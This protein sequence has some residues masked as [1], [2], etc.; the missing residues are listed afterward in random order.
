MSLFAAYL[1][2]PPVT[3][4]FFN[5][6]PTALRAALFPTVAVVP[7]PK[8]PRAESMAISPMKFS[9]SKSW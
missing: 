1:L 3:A 4:W 5:E 8:P 2:T 7:A 9:A 6:S